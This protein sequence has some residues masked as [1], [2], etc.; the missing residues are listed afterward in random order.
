MTQTCLWGSFGVGYKE[1]PERNIQRARDL[2]AHFNAWMEAALAKHLGGRWNRN[3][4]VPFVFLKHKGNRVGEEIAGETSEFLTR[5]I[6]H[7]L[8][9]IPGEPAVLPQ[10]AL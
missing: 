8:N 7:G 6:L 9:I 5:A 3:D 1:L 4:E 10:K 2:M